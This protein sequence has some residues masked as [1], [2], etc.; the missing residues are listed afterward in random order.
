MKRNS[1]RRDFLFGKPANPPAGAGDMLSGVPEAS[2]ESYL[3]RISRPAMACEFEICLRAGQYANGSEVAIAALDLVEQLEVQ[4][5]V[6]RDQSELSRINATAADGPVEVESRLFDLLELAMRLH[7]ETDGAYDITAGPLWEVWGFAR[8]AGA[9]PQPDL[10]EAA[11]RQ[12]GSHLVELDR[13]RKTIRFLQPGVRLNLGSIGKGFAVDR[14][15]ETLLQAGIEDFLVHGGNS[16]IFAH[17]SHAPSAAA[18]PAGYWTVGIRDPLRLEQRLAEVRLSNRGLGTSAAQFQSFRHQGRRYGHI[19]DPR[20]GWPAEGVL[21]STVIAPS[22]ALAD[23]LSTAF[24]VLGPEAAVS[25]CSQHPEIGA[26][27]ICPTPNGGIE[28]HRAGLTEDQW[29]A[30]Q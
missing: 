29:N 9:V 23:G 8:R 5:S 26:I 2:D 13:E 19:L 25:Y 12:V 24:Y 20:T 16:S 3:V 28:V 14:C 17:G 10:L 7:G 27:M 22:A 21:S 1:S 11:R 18:A 6:F 15:C 4:M 30:L